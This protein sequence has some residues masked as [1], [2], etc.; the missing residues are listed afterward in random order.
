[1]STNPRVFEDIEIVRVHFEK[2]TAMLTTMHGGLCEVAKS[3]VSL[4]G[5]IQMKGIAEIA[6]CEVQEIALNLEGGK[7]NA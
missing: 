3:P 4:E 5:A 1:M 2:L 7:T 6:L